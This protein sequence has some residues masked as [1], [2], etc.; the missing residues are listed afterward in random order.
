MPEPT[1]LLLHFADEA[2]LAGR[3]AA[4]LG[5]P[6]APIA[7]HVF[8][9]GEQRLTL[10]PVLPH[11]VWLLRGLQQ[12]NDKLAQLMLVAP[13]ARELG[14]HRLGLVAPYLAYQRQDM[15]FSPGEVVSQRQLGRALASW[16]DVVVTLDPHLHRV[17]SL[18]EVMPGRRG[19]ALSAAAAIGAYVAARRPQA[20]LLGPDEESRP[21]V[22]AAAAARGLE[23]A[24]CHKDRRGDLEVAVALPDVAL[25]GRAVVLVDDVASSGRTLAAAARRA[26]AAGAASVDAAVTHA[27]FCGDALEV[28]RAAGVG[29]VWSSDSVPHPSNR[30][31]VAPLIA[32]AIRALR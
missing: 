11:D 12:P 6:M 26:F 9:D 29:E 13:A 32:D 16:F 30:I 22:Q 7:C 27:L 4:A 20:L 2:A 23:H 17:A 21:W 8:P 28:V 3:L 19:V 31:E 10:P 15:A 18:D 25:R 24:W 1:R 14:A 5:V